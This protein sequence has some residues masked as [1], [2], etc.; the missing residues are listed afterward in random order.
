MSP[1][2]ASVPGRQSSSLSALVYLNSKQSRKGAAVGV[3]VFTTACQ[4]LQKKFHSLP[5]RWSSA[6]TFETMPGAGSGE[7]YRSLSEA[8][9][10]RSWTM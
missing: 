7:G 4:L 6:M 3:G 9:S 10:S 8:L 2:A 5:L 1:E